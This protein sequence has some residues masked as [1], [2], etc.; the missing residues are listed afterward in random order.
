MLRHENSLRCSGCGVCSNQRVES[1]EE[2]TCVSGSCTSGP[3]QKQFRTLV[4]ARGHR[5]GIVR[6][7]AA[8]VDRAGTHFVP[9]YERVGIA[10]MYRWEEG[11]L[12]VCSSRLGHLHVAS[13]AHLNGKRLNLEEPGGTALPGYVVS[14][15]AIGVA[16]CHCAGCC[17]M[18][19]W[20][21]A[22]VPDGLVDLHQGDILA[23]ALP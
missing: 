3:A 2:G 4:R 20:K 9:G 15:M 18:L 23:D 12:A 6:V 7:T 16:S 13:S 22:T 14:S 5:R 21:C 10:I 17:G 19:K 1:G 8:T 11:C